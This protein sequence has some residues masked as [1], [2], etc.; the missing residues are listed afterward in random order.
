MKPAR[1]LFPTQL[2]VPLVIVAVIAIAVFTGGRE[3][4][5][6]DGRPVVV[7]AHPPCPPDLM[8]FFDEAFDDFRRQHP[9]IDLRVLHIT[10]NYEDKIKV[11]CAGE[12]A[13]DVIF[14]YPEALPAWVDLNALLPLDDLM[15]RDGKVGRDDYFRA[16]IETFSWKG[17]LY[18]LPKDASADLVFYNREMFVERGVPLPTPEW[19]WDDYLAA[20]QKL[21][22]DTDHDGRTDIFGATQPEWDRMV[23]QNGG[24]VISEDA[25]RCLL[26]QAQSIE[27]LERWAA[28]RTEHKVTPTPESTMDS[29]T[30]NLFAT[31]RLAMFNS[32]YPCVPILRRTC[33]F[34]WDIALPPRGP[35]RSFSSFKGSALAITR[36]SRNQEAAFTFARWMTTEGMRHVMSFDIPCYKPLGESTEWRDPKVLPASKQIAVD[37]MDRSGPP[38]VSHPH[39]SQITDVILPRLDRVN[40][41]TSTVEQEV[42]SIVA[43]VDAILLRHAQRRGETPR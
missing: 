14:M 32:I 13:P 26:D 25:S 4:E 5:D 22:Q 42:P 2:L 23:I 1:F 12:V 39:A 19:T 20:A 9:H 10:G 27:A 29:S 24:R 33:D 17:V 3:T 11:M 7:Y 36:Q 41:D 37:V 15:A 34:E 38:T 30:W 35:A 21:T 40:R 6:S 16:G 43:E 18:G 8:A 31:R 28:L